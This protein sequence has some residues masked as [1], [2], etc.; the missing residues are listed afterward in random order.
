MKKIL[1]ILLLFCFFSVKAQDYNK[2]KGHWVTEKSE[3]NLR[4]YFNKAQKK[5]VFWQY[6]EVETLDYYNC[7]IKSYKYLPIRYTGKENGKLKGIILYWY[8]QN[9]SAYFETTY[10]LVEKNKLK[11]VFK[12][13]Y[14]FTYYYKRKEI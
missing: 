4:I 5:L 12:G 10:E 8:N 11:V 3:I 6:K 1:L 13:D 14:N 9:E 2:F 7:K